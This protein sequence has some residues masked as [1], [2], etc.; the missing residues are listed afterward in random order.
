MQSPTTPKLF[1][2][3]ICGQ[4]LEMQLCYL[5]EGTNIELVR[6]CL[7][8]PLDM[9]DLWVRTLSEEISSSPNTG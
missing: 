2:A 8:T 4:S 1:A 9:Y 6:E 3:L 7:P 5:L